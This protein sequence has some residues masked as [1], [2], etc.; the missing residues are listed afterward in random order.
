NIKIIDFNLA[1]SL[2]KVWAPICRPNDLQGTLAYMSPE[3]T[4]RMNRGIDFRTDFYSLG[5]TFY[6]MLTGQLPFPSQDPLEIIYGHIAIIPKAPNEIDPSI[7]EVISL[8]VMKLLAK[9]AEDRYQNPNGLLKDLMNCQSQLKTKQTIH[10]FAL[11]TQD[12]FTHFQIPEKLYG[13]SQEIQIFLKTYEDVVQGKIKLLLLTGDSGIGKSMLAHEIQKRIVEKRGY[14]ISGK[15][16]RLNN[17]IPYTAFTQAFN[18]LINLILTESE[19]K[20]AFFKKKILEGVKD[21]VQIIIDVI[22]NLALIIEEYSSAPK[23]DPTE[24]QNRFRKVFQDF[25]NALTTPEHPLTIYL[26]DLQWAD[27]NSLKLL[28]ILVTS[29]SCRYLLIIGAYRTL[30]MGSVHPLMM[31]IE[32]LKR[33]N[34]GYESIYLGPLALT[35]IKELLE[36][37][38][39]KNKEQVHQLAEI[40]DKKTKGNP[41]FL[42]QILQTLYKEQIIEFDQGINEWTWD[43]NKIQEKKTTDNVVDLLIDKM[44]QLSEVGRR[45]IKSAASIGNLFNSDILCCI[46]GMKF[47]EVFV[48]LTEIME[49]GF[50]LR[51]GDANGMPSYQFA[52]DRIQQAAYQ[53]IPEKERPILHYHIGQ[54]ILQSSDEKNLGN[55]LFTIVNQLNYGVDIIESEKE[56]LRLTNLN[57]LAGKRA[58][59]SSAY[60]VAVDYFK[61]GINLLPKDHW[62]LEYDLS[63]AL[64][65]NSAV[66][67]SLTGLDDQSK[68]AFD[69]ALEHVQ[70]SPEKAK[71]YFDKGVLYLRQSNFKE[72]L[73]CFQQGLKLYGISVQLEP[74]KISLFLENV[75]LKINLAFKGLDSIKVSKIKDD[76][77]SMIFY[78][79]YLIVH[80][81][82]MVGLPSLLELTAMTMINMTFTYGIFEH[83]SFSFISLAI[84]SG[85]EIRQNYSLSYKWGRKA[86]ELANLF[87]NAEVSTNTQVFFYCFISRFGIPIKENVVYLKNLINQCRV[88][89]SHYIFPALAHFGA[90]AFMKGESLESCE[91]EIQQALDEKLEQKKSLIF[92]LL[93]HILELCQNLKNSSQ[94]KDYNFIAQSEPLYKTNPLFYLGFS[95]FN[96]YQLYS[97]GKYEEILVICE[98][99]KPFRH[100][101][102][103][104][105][106]W[107]YC[108]FYQSL[109]LTAM[110]ILDTKKGWESIERLQQRIRRWAEACPENYLQYYL[111]L[112]AEVAR[113][114]NNRLQAIE[115]YEN[116]IKAAQKNGF[117]QDEA[118]ANELLAKFYLSLGKE[119]IAKVYLEE[120]LHCYLLWGAGRKVTQLE[121]NYGILLEKRK[122]SSFLRTLKPTSI[123]SIGVSG[124]ETSEGLDMWT[125]QKCSQTISS[126]IVL[127]DLLKKLMYILIENAGARR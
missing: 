122:Q 36:D 91:K 22:P 69:I 7:S 119:K 56:K 26:D 89:G 86:V 67:L 70:A 31:T 42:I 95:S 105:T 10:S 121:Q 113:L 78:L 85:S 65:V 124:K 118:L 39:H 28:E 32:N 61:I 43:L 112:S 125:I 2:P 73:T 48:A 50:V 17:T 41:F 52:H 54:L 15:F 92:A 53:L 20:I 49:G 68:M 83:S 106:F 79:Y 64:Y 120:A 88:L 14:F 5:V 87:P 108:Y 97:E 35:H 3:Q 8:I 27:L 126:T 90:Y 24:S 58:K 57:L 82:F 38:L 16:D 81:A 4:G 117:L 84:F 76:R 9:N 111:L 37:T 80:I 100:L 44:A 63:V 13:R 93:S 6:Q 115:L 18:E 101:F 71:I 55:E 102:P 75:K 29:Y 46:C 40:C 33:K 60:Q 104:H 30:E 62:L 110:G 59:D 109:A 66:C 19:E 114:Q 1:T 23:L 11:G 116:S 74:S 45:V 25:I 34:V 123:P 127:T 96:I 99:L 94:Q 47:E 98:Q 103:S 21:N 72:A 107:V 51:R 12:I 77:I